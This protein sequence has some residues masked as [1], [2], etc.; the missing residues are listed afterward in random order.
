MNICEARK[1][2]RDEIEK[3]DMIMD[4]NMLCAWAEEAK[5]FLFS[6]DEAPAENVVSIIFNNGYLRGMEY[7]MFVH[8]LAPFDSEEFVAKVAHAWRVLVDDFIERAGAKHYGI[9]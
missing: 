7:Q 1:F 2:I 3:V 9:E 6:L 4:N 5:Q 8:E